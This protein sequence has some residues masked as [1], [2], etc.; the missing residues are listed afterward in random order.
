MRPTMS[1]KGHSRLLKVIH[2]YHIQRT[3]FNIFFAF[4]LVIFLFIYLYII[5]LLIYSPNARLI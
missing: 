5:Y 1:G 4:L 3:P 2:W